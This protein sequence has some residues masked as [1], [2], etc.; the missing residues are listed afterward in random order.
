MRRLAISCAASNMRD[1]HSRFIEAVDP[2][3]R[4]S[5]SDVAS[6]KL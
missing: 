6:F 4:L 2:V 3:F 5:I 1:G